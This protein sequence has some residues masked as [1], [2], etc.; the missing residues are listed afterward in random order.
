VFVVEHGTARFRP[1]RSGII[2][3]LD[4][5]VVG[6]GESTEVVVGPFQLLKDLKDG[7][8]VR[9]RRQDTR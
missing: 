6:V 9:P 4:V 7:D 3:G 2:G 5:E 1:V 8:P